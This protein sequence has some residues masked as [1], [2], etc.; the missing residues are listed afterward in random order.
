MSTYL[1]YKTLFNLP[2]KKLRNLELSSFFIRMT[3]M[4]LELKLFFL[5]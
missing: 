1:D 3:G 4:S 2:K 5:K